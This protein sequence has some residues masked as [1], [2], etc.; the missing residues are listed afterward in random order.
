MS[1]PWIEASRAPNV[2][3]TN[4]HASAITPVIFLILHVSWM[5]VGIVFAVIVCI[6]ILAI[7]GRSVTWLLNKAKSRMRGGVVSARPFY[8]RR[9]VNRVQSYD[10]CEMSIFRKV[11]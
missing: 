3:L 6:V 2:P 9:R 8:Y 11:G 4:A 5:T 10:D 1:V 7:K